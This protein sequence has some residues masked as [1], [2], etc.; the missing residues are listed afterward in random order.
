MKK[1]KN[2]GHEMLKPDDFANQDPNSEYCSTCMKK[3]GT[4]RTYDEFREIMVVHL[5]TSEG[6][7]LTEQLKLEPAKNREE[8]EKL[9][10]WV[11]NLMAEHTPELKNKKE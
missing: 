10:D 4:L 11:M 1:C 5:L 8:A 3:D 2:C 7:K 9:A 6:R